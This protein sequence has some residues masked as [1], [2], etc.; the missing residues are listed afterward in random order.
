M[1]FV[2]NAC[3][4]VCAALFSLPL[5]ASPV[6]QALVQKLLVT[7][8][9]QFQLQVT[10]SAP[11]SP[12]AQI[13]DEPERLV[14]DIPNATPIAGLHS[15]NVN[16]SEVTR[17]RVGLFSTTPPVTRIVLDL[18]SPQWY[19]IEPSASGF[20]VTLGASSPAAQEGS[21]SP[22]VGWVSARTAATSANRADPFVIRKPA[23]AAVSSLDSS[24]SGARVRFSNGILEIHARNTSLSEVLFQIH[25]QTGAEIAIPAG[26]EQESVVA[27]FGPAPVREVLSQLLNGTDLNFVA[28]G[29]AADPDQLRSVLLS[30][31]N[32]GYAET[33]PEYNPSPVPSNNPPQAVD[34]PP[35]DT[36]DLDPQPDQNPQPPQ[37]QEQAAPAAEAPPGS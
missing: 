12:Q 11:V 35:G 13:V 27:D 5:F 1:Q 4:F 29:S 9:E 18:N 37:P 25:K 19:R 33:T 23:A 3:Q 16:R 21:V 7:H 30:R 6:P 2:K 28:V 32:A 17:V 15:A 34:V 22:S 20:T 14:I 8:Q 26:T 24:I 36:P 10:T 31:K